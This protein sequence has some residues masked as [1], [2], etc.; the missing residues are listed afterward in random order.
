MTKDA[1]LT[2]IRRNL[3]RGPLPADQQA[4]LAGRLASHPRH[5]V[6]ARALN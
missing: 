5:L 1:I 2:R 4:M 6:P 3:K